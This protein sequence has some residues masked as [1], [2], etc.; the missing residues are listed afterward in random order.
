MENTRRQDASIRLQS[1]ATKTRPNRKTLYF[2]S[3]SSPSSTHFLSFSL[4]RNHLASNGRLTMSKARFSLFRRCH[5]LRLKILLGKDSSASTSLLPKNP[6]TLHLSSPL[7]IPKI[8]CRTKLFLPRSL[9]APK[10][11][12][13]HWQGIEIKINLV[14]PRRQSHQ[15]LANRNSN[16]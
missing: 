16:P 6:L 11:I 14:A 7:L 12:F 5:F 13:F 4:G 15:K 1:P 2:L 10:V 8:R 3:T 9:P